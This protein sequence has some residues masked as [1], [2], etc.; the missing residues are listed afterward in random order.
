[1][2]ADSPPM[3][4]MSAPAPQQLARQLD[5]RLERRV[6][7]AV[8]EGVGRGVDDAHQPRTRAQLEHR[9][10][11]GRCSDDHERTLMSAHDALGLGLLGE[12]LRSPAPHALGAPAELAREHVGDALDRELQLAR[13]AAPGACGAAARR[14]CCAPA[15]C[16]PPAPPRPAGRAGRERSAGPARRA[17]GRQR[18]HLVG[19]VAVAGGQRRVGLRGHALHARQLL[20]GDRLPER[21]L[22]GAAGSVARVALD[23]AVDGHLRHPPPGRELAPGDRD[24]AAG[25]L[26]QLGLARDV[27]RLLRVAG[28]DQ[29]THARRRRPSDVRC[30]A[31]SR[32]TR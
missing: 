28:R 26:I 6:A 12:A 14:R 5:L 29:R 31:P 25:G 24:H 4:R 23:E 9:R 27:H 16:A 15:R 20:H 19:G 7:A 11:H 32:R 3:S 22:V 2:L 21:D 10:P 1:M 30:R 18:E 13:R 17:L 8:A